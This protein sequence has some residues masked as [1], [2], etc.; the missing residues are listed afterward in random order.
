MNFEL[1]Q[2]T[3]LLGSKFVVDTQIGPVEL[4]LV[5]A[6]ELPRGSRPERFRTPLSLIFNTPP[7]LNLEQDNYWIE[8]PA[9]GRHIW[10]IAQVLPPFGVPQTP[11]TPR[12]Y[13]VL[14]S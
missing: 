9:I 12:Y 6:E 7:N 10:T 14:F 2:F 5:E 4:E 3:P 13:Q 11:E 1:A 8:H